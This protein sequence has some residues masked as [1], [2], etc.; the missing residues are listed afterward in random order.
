M[1]RFIAILLVFCLANFF[2]LE[3]ASTASIARSQGQDEDYPYEPFSPEQLDNL[4]APIALYPDP[5]LS[6]VLV[7]AT[8]VDEVDEAARWVR[9]NGMNRVDD[10]PW[11]VSVKA[12]AHYPTVISMMANKIDW[13]TSVGQAYVNQSTDVMTSIQRLRHMARDVGNLVTTPQ[14][15]VLVEDDYISIV[16]YQPTYI[17][18][19]VYDP[20]ICYYRRPVWGLAI[21]FG[22]GFLIGAW[23]NRDCDWHHHRVYYHGW[24]GGGWVERCRPHVRI[25]NVYVNNRYENVTINRRVI[26]RNVNV[27]NVSRYNYIHRDLSYKNVQ[28]N[29]DRANRMNHVRPA[30]GPARQPV[31]NRNLNRNIDTTNPRLDQYRGRERTAPGGRPSQG[32]PSER[33]GRSEA[34]PTRAGPPPTAQPTPG[35]RPPQGPPSQHQGRPETPGQPGRSAAPPPTQTGPPST[36]RPTPAPPPQPAPHTFGTKGGNFDPRATSQRGQSSREQMK[37]GSRAPR[38]SP[39]PRPSPAP[40]S[41]PPPK[42]SPQPRSA[43]QSH[44]PSKPTPHGGETRRP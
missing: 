44:A 33:Q 42:T 43:P 7:A 28:A 20:Y 34:P 31:D 26:N 10:Q 2:L 36:A 4:L 18:V 16:P 15:Q 14:Q 19:P 24:H 1:Q 38:S 29:N 25:T 23:L 39:Q 8:F 27:N 41:G 30:K 5:L 3:R 17:Y 35:G 6:Q 11:D 13:T 9:A 32:P 21:T 22:T 40:R 37:Q 12:V